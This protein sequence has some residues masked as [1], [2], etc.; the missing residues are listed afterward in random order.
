MQTYVALLRG[1]NVGG[2]ARVPMEEL[3]KV[4]VSLGYVSVSTYI[5]SGNV[6][7]STVEKSEKILEATIEQALK[8][9]F[10]FRIATLVRTGES[11]KKLAEVIPVHWVNDAS[12]KTDILFLWESHDSATSLKKISS[13]PD[14]DTLKYLDGVIVWHCNRSQYAKSGMHKFVGTEIYKHMTA[15]NINTVRKLAARVSSS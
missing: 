9:E 15:R 2:K 7:F 14:V 4:F 5:N 6:I 12:Y 3:K 8:K 11:I 1:V 13:N 10:K